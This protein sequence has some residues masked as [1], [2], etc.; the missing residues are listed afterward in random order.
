MDLNQITLPVKDVAAAVFFYQKLGFTLIVSAPHYA[1][2]QATQGRST[3]S[4]HA[5]DAMPAD[6][7]AVVYFECMLLDRQVEQLRAAGVV[8]LQEPCDQDWGW[9]EARLKDPSGNTLC[10]YTAK[11]YR[12][13]PPWRVGGPKENAFVTTTLDTPRLTLRAVQLSDLPELLE[14]N[15]DT[16]VNQFLPYAAWTSME[17]AYGWFQR[18]QQRTVDGDL[19]YR[20]LVDKQSSRVLGGCLL[21]YY[22]SAS[23]R[24][25]LGYL[26]GRFSWGQGFMREAAS[27][28][29]EDGFS[30]MGLRRIEAQINP[31]NTAS[32]RVVEGL[33]FQREG[34]LRERWVNKG[35]PSDCAFYGLLRED[36]VKPSQSAN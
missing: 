12:L 2:F 3:F 25:E 31:L 7:G 1:R 35:V 29:V 9:R 30:R 19:V 24:A 21:M 32:C 36:W 11:E 5:V 17:D 20:V 15:R 33:G 13:N 18:T 23:S 8:F 26:Q 34:V 22:D 16:E 28:I 4:L 10:L 27:A 6:S 14:I